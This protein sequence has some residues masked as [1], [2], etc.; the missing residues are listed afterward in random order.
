MPITI[1]IYRY[2]LVCQNE[3]T[4]QFGKA[5]LGKILITATSLVPI[6]GTALSVVYSEDRWIY[7]NCI[8][9]EETFYLHEEEVDPSWWNTGRFINQPIYYPVRLFHHLLGI[10]YFLMTPMVYCAIYRFLRNHDRTVTGK[11]IH[12]NSWV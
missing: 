9:R 10:T 8:G 1:A 5:K 12:I 7:I 6:L 2:M 3:K 4:E 11:Y